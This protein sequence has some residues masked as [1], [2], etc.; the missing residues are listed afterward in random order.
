MI[1]SSLVYSSG[2]MLMIR[3]TDNVITITIIELVAGL[4]SQE[5]YRGCSDCSSLL[6]SHFRSQRQDRST[7]ESILMKNHPKI[8]T[9]RRDQAVMGHLLL[10]C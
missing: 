4:Q 1:D 3:F 6:A 7:R 10:F 5:P 9:K 2:R 8:W